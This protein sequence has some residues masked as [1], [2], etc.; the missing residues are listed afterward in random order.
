[1][2]ASII[3]TAI[4]AVAL[5][6]TSVSAR[7]QAEYPNKCGDMYPSTTT[8]AAPPPATPTFGPKCGDSFFCKPGQVCCTLYTCADTPDQCPK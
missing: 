6:G 7:P 4:I 5:A 1:M 8:T 3:K 2:Y